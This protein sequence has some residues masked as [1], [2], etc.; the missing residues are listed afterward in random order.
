[1]AKAEFGSNKAQ[2]YN[3]KHNWLLSWNTV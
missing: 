2:T 1:M 3:I